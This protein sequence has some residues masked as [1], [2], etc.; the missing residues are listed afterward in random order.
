MIRFASGVGDGSPLPSASAILA[1][2]ASRSVN[3]LPVNSTASPARSDEN[4]DT[5]NPDC[6]SIARGPLI[7]VWS[8]C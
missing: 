3:T 7:T 6:H 8:T 5:G 2:L 1:A 4:S